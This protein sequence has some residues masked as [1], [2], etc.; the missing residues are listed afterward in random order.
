MNG[1]EFFKLPEE[2]WPVQ[3]TTPRREED[4]ERRQVN[5][6]TSVLYEDIGKVIDVKKFSSWPRLIRVT[7]WI[8][9]LAETIRLRGNALTGREGPLMPEELKKAEMSW[10]RKAQ[11]DL[12]SRMKS[13]E[14]K[15]LS[16]FVR[17]H[18]K[19][20]IRVG[21]RINKAIMLQ[22]QDENTGS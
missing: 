15:T 21:G 10:I 9:R 18:D 22:K 12:K 1:T 16:T 4:M 11:K 6:V 5:A 8:K 14:F 7:A 19:G 3:T 20:I 17:V 13:G 2:Q